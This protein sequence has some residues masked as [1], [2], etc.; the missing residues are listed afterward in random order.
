MTFQTLTPADFE[1]CPYRQPLNSD[2]PSSCPADIV[3]PEDPVNH[4]VI[5]SS[6][7]RTLL[8]NKQSCAKRDQTENEKWTEEERNWAAKAEVV[9]DKHDLMK[10]LADFY[11][12]GGKDQS[13]SYVRIK[14]V[15]FP[16]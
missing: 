9:E 2:N 1:S 14:T 11:P 7:D 6:Y 15:T 4:I 12:N 3:V 16:K 13:R 8:A 5:H 10:K